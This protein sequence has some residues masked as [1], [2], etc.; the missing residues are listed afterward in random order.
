MLRS[1]PT[2]RNLSIEQHSRVDSAYT[3]ELPSVA[4][5]E[6]LPS[7]FYATHR[8]LHRELF[9]RDLGMSMQIDRRTTHR[10]TE[11]FQRVGLLSYMKDGRR[12]TYPLSRGLQS[13]CMMSWGL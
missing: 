3:V 4:L 9:D 2:D 11:V 13:G 12:N 8:N 5:V 7:S 1:T 6:Q 10:E